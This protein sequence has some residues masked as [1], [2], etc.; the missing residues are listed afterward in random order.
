MNTIDRE[1]KTVVLTLKASQTEVNLM[2]AEA[3]KR[4]KKL[5]TMIRESIL[6]EIKNSS[7]SPISK[8]AT[9]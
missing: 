7:V 3:K 9:A 1:V 2:K 4:G 6:G 5:S 8:A